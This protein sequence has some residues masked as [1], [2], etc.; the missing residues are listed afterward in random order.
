VD[1]STSRF[2]HCVGDWAQRFGG[3]NVQCGLPDLPELTRDITTINL[4]FLRLIREIARQDKVTAAYKFG[5]SALFVDRITRC[6]IQDLEVM[7]A[8]SELMF[9]PRQGLA[10]EVLLSTV[11]AP[12]STDTQI[13]SVRTVTLLAD[14]LA[15]PVAA[16]G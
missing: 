13:R 11:I 7:A 12:D 15:N 1:N 2:V 9:S 6:T 8:S 5:V 14:N 4:S 16:A 3:F 10:L